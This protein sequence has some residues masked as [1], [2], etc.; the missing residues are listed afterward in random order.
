MSSVLDPGFVAITIACLVVMTVAM[1]ANNVDRILERR[2]NNG[3][4]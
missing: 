3:H 2:E 1:V 4:S